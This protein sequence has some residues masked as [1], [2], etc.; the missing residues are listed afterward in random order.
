MAQLDCQILNWNVRGMNDGAQQD[1]VSELVR[2]TG[3][4]IVC[5]QET[6]MQVWIIMWCAAQ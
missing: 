5:L 4:T 1:S 2:T 6:K 3:A